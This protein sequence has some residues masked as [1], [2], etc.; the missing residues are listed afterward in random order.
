MTGAKITPQDALHER[1]KYQNG[2]A[3][4]NSPSF[5]GCMCP[6]YRISTALDRETI[7]HFTL[8]ISN[9][10]YPK[11]PDTKHTRTAYGHAN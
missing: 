8:S 2:G 7:I 4:L 9:I 10:Q 5:S 1:E 3:S 6:A 11:I